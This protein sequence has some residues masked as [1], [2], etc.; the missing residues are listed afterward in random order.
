MAETTTAEITSYPI[1]GFAVGKADTQ[2]G[3]L[4]FIGGFTMTSPNRDFGALSSFRFLD[5]AGGRFAAVA[6]T[7]HFITGTVLRDETGRPTGFSAL[8]FTTLPDLND[9]ISDAKWETDSESLLVEPGSVVIGFERRH[10][11]SRFAFDGQTL[12][13]RIENLDFL[14]PA[15][16]LRSNRGFETIAKAPEDGPLAG[17][18]VAISEKS[19]DAKG[20]IFAAVLS[21]PAKGVFSIAR[22]NEFD[23]TD[24]AFLPSGDLIILE[25]AYQMA[26]GVRMRLRRIDGAAIRSGAVVDGE[27]LLEADMRHQIDNMEG[28]DIWQAPDGTTRLSLVSDD[29]KSIL[30]R[31]LYLEFALSE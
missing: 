29:N 16:E 7:G 14:I 20:N 18:I 10:R 26:K 4:T 22:S 21:G 2:F 27:I 12:G 25:R 19:I 31:N 8:T 24:G 28:L 1:A 6:D 30:Q 23:I 3:R 11:L 17:A 5:A 15:S 13:R 9:Q